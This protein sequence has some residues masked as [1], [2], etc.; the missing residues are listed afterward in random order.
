MNMRVASSL[1]LLDLKQ[2]CRHLLSL[3]FVLPLIQCQQRPKNHEVSS[4]GLE[5]QELYQA[6][7]DLPGLFPLFLPS[8]FSSLT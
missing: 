5:G 1:G 8:T 4:S 3:R 7:C 6:L 2:L